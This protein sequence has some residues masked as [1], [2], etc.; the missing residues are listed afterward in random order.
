VSPKFL[1]VPPSL[2]I[3]AHQFTRQINATTAA[4]VNPFSSQLQVIVDARLEDYSSTAWYLAADPGLIDG[5][6]YAHLAGAEGP[7][8]EMQEG[9]NVLGVEFRVVLDFGCAAIDHRGWLKNLGA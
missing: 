6:E 9:W 7:Q 4:T 2:E 3:V 5:L 8:L 1:L